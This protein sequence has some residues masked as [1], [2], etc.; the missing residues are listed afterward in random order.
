MAP[1]GGGGRERGEEAHLLQQW[2]A[3]AVPAEDHIVAAL[4]HRRIAVPHQVDLRAHLIALAR[5]S[6][7]HEPRACLPYSRYSDPP[8]LMRGIHS[9]YTAT[10]EA[11]GAW[12][13]AGRGGA[14][15]G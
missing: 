1:E 15:A 8:T 2:H 5:Q 14:R 7:C 10:L 13:G 12:W 4:H 6:D 9:G 11:C 3:N